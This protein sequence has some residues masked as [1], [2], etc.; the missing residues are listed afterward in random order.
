MTSD[1]EMLK[2]W[3]IFKRESS[4]HVSSYDCFI[5][6]YTQGRADAWRWIAVDDDL[7]K[8]Q[9]LVEYFLAQEEKENG[10]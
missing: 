9:E 2:A 5:S 10:I 7:P 1:E 4:D 6:A 3:R 8:L